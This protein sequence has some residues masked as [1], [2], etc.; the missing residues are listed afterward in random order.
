MLGFLFMRGYN[1]VD[2]KN[3]INKTKKEALLTRMQKYKIFERDIQEKFIRSK[4]KGGQNV[5]KSATCVYL[6]HKLTGIE[7]KCHTERSQ[8]LNRF[9]ARRRLVNKIETLILG[10]QSEER[11]RIE[12]IRRQKRKRS[13][14]AK[15]KILKLKRIRSDKKKL[16]FGI[17]AYSE[18]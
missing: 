18:E 2:M 6:K 7:V 5:N 13:K 10:K 11:R 3:I 4:G 1:L 15:E 8:F 14:R 12:K 9:L 17:D 16:R